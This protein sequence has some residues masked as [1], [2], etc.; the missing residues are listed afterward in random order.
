VG[1]T[2]VEESEELLAEFG[3]AGGAFAGCV[4]GVRHAVV[5]LSSVGFDWLDAGPGAG[6]AEVALSTG[7]EQKFKEF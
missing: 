6:E 1:L 2:T 5:L 4:G 7:R 3:G